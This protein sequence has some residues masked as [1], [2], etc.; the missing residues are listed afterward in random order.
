MIDDAVEPVIYRGFFWNNPLEE[1]IALK[2]LCRVEG[3]RLEALEEALVLQMKRSSG[4]GC[5][6][7]IPDRTLLLP[8]LGVRI[9]YG[10]SMGPEIGLHA[11]DGSARRGFF[12]SDE[13]L[14]LLKGIERSGR[15]WWKLW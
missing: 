9:V 5:V 6:P 7:G 2:P 10:G 15:P 8:S 11:L 4:V 3:R 13:F 12:H 1:V 14:N